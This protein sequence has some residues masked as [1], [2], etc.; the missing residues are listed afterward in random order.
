MTT[1][2][3]TTEN[4]VALRFA[5]RAT[6]YQALSDL[7]HLSSPAADVRGAVLIERL[8]DGTVRVPEGLETAAGRNTAVGGLVGSVVGILGGPLGVLMGWGIGAMIGGGYDF[9]RAGEATEAAVAFTPHVAP[10]G[11]AILAEVKES[12]TQV[13]DLLAMRY[14]AVLERRP[15]DGVRAELKAMEEAAEQVR[16]E[17]AKTR[18]EQKRAE[19]AQKFHRVTGGRREGEAA[20]EETPAG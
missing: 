2:T 17:E 7:K 5:D 12:D 19:V 4:A 13:L 6:A 10:G 8:D 3:T 15:V 14:D 9:K 18:R 11:T 20:P 16:K 1:N